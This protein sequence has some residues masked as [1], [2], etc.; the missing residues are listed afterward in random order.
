M[1]VTQA[2]LD[3][4]WDF[5]N[6]AGSELRLRSAAEA[7]LDAGQRAAWA[8]WQT[9]VARALG[10]QE[11]F[12][13]AE[14][15]LGSVVD[16][17]APPVTVRVPLERGRLRQSAGDP[18]A[19]AAL[20]RT[21]AELASAALGSGV[22]GPRDDDE[23]AASLAFLRVDALHMLAIAEPAAVESWTAEALSALQAVTDPRTLR[24]R[25]SLYNNLGWA[26]LDAGRTAEAVAAFESARDA[27]V[28][29]GTA[30]QLTWADEALA[31]A[32]GRPVPGGRTS[33]AV[34][35]AWSLGEV[36]LYV[37]DQDSSREFYR[38]LLGSDPCLDVPGMT[39]FQLSPALKLGLMPERGIARILGDRVPHPASGAGIPRAELYFEVPDV[40]QAYDRALAA[41][42]AGIDPPAHRDWGDVVGY[43]ADPDGHILAFATPPAG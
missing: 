41:G 10:L 16:L 5:A 36:I 22:T 43:A 6:P 19:A 13:E 23:L 24:W 40:Q 34:G 30:Q 3:G 2:E 31:E 29:W 42:A 39:E 25:V 21:A 11:R 8:E 35:M 17:D 27:A 4:C 38:A 28:R 26:L 1:T 12:A 37:A 7:A 32:R 20:F 14:A 9:Q 18:Q 33:A 15:V